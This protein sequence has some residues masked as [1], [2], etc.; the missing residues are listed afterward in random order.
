MYG[1]WRDE[2]LFDDAR[3]EIIET[4]ATDDPSLDEHVCQT[5]RPGYALGERVLRA[6]QV[7]VYTLER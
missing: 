1:S 2:G 4:R 7:V 5:I 3:Q 6:Q